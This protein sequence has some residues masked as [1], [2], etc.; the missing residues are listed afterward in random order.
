MNEQSNPELRANERLCPECGKAVNLA[1]TTCVH[2]GAPLTPLTTPGSSP[3]PARSGTGLDPKVAGALTYVFTFV[4]GIIFLL[5]E[6]DDDY[7]RFHA[8]QAVAFGVA[9]VAAWIAL[10]IASI[11]LVL[12]PWIG[13]ILIT[14]ASVVIWVGALVLWIVLMVKAY[15]GER[16]QLPFLGDLGQKVTAS[17]NR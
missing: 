14:L 9:V 1:A 12:I 17:V 7:V 2:C 4:T 8:G 13:P 16:F 5:I 3:Q 11:I 10:T 6:K 15:Q